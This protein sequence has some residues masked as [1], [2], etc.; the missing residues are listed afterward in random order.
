MAKKPI[1]PFYAELGRRINSARTSL[2]LTQ[3]A[4][5]SRL[6]PP[7]TRAA[8]ANIETGKQRV[9]AHTLADLAIKLGVGLQDLV[10]K[11]NT[12]SGLADVQA[13]LDAKF[14]PALSSSLKAHLKPKSEVNNEHP[15]SS[16]AS[17]TTDN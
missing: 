4:L 3:G 6:K 11:Q 1:E 15:I 8:I 5:G 12:D 9:L 17:R 7:L 16:E 13:E 2:S 14:S 10:P